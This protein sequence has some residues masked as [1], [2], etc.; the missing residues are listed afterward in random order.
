[1]DMRIS[2]NIEIWI[3]LDEQI[4]SRHYWNLSRK[5]ANECNIATIINVAWVPRVLK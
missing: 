5:K 4:V 2:G 3:V 1:M